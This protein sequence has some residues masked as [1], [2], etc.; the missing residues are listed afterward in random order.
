MQ[1]WIL[2]FRTDDNYFIYKKMADKWN[3]RQKYTDFW[4]NF[5]ESITG[6]IQT[7][8]HGV[9]FTLDGRW[10]W[11][12]TYSIVKTSNFRVFKCCPFP[13]WFYSQG[14]LWSVFV[15]LQHS[16]SISPSYLAPYFP[17]IAL[18]CFSTLYFLP[19]FSLL[20]IKA[21]Y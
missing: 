11:T 8:C 17:C 6:F 15:P 14:Y 18:N 20:Y 9:N 10:Q 2:F 3:K 16:F 13:I 12:S 1:S 4:K 7:V 21:P 19:F 5:T